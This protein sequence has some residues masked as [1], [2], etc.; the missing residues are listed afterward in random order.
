MEWH[1]RNKQN[2]RWYTVEIDCE[3]TG[4]VL[5]MQSWGGDGKRPS[6]SRLHRFHSLLDANQV[7]QQIHKIRLRHGYALAPPDQLRLS[8]AALAHELDS[9]P[10]ELLQAC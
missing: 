7:R 4:D 3:A 10:V 6:G 8:F 2:R 5:L 9:L 1:Y